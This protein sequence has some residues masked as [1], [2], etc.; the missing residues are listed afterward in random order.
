MS[1]VL[2]REELKRRVGKLGQR[3]S[4]LTLLLPSLLWA[5]GFPGG[6]HEALGPRFNAGVRS[7]IAPR[8]AHRNGV[9]S[10]HY[11]NEIAINATGI[12]HTPGIPGAVF[13]E[14]LGPG[15]ASRAMA[16]VHIAIF[17]AVN[18][19]VGGYQ[20]YTGLKPAGRDTSMEAAIA[21]AARDTLAALF[22][23]QTASF[24]E[25][26]AADLDQIPDGPPKRHGVDLGHLAAGTV[27]ALRQSDGS[28]Y[29]EPRIGVDFITSDEPGKWR[30]D[31]IS[32][33]PLAL[34]AYWGG[35]TPFVLQSAQKFRVPP[36]PELVFVEEVD[37]F[38]L[39]H[40]A[41]RARPIGAVVWTPSIMNSCSA[42]AISTVC[43]RSSSWMTS[44]SRLS[45]PGLIGA[46]SER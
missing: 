15:R 27:L 23:A 31:P 20:S 10:V 13:G 14:Q 2:S 8:R 3:V 41:I 40:P 4:F 32:L 42:R 29:V 22:P 35:V 5:Q 1:K 34:G 24:D 7:P 46:S 38:E 30:Q 37:F 43:R 44:R 12:D 36:P 17:D 9:D 21:Q 11:W 39:E 25:L 6:V 18:A 28:Q 19:I 16:I 33:I 26:L 45:S